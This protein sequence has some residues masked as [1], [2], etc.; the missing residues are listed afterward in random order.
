M[1]SK[2]TQSDID[3]Q[4]QKVLVGKII[5]SI[6]KKPEPRARVTTHQPKSYN[7]KIV[8]AF[9]AEHGI[10]EPEYEYQFA[11]DIGRKWRF[12]L[13]IIDWSMRD[14]KKMEPITSGSVAIEVQGGI[15]QA[16]R[17]NRGAAMLQEWEKLNEAA[18]RGWR[19]IFVQ[20]SELCMMN[21]ATLIQRALGIKK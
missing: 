15:F 13:A 4:N 20:P 17:H 1:K 12:D 11:A 2:F 19:I 18:A 6:G 16:G 5:A 9:F 7:P 10:P 8:T 3:R 21:T 14:G